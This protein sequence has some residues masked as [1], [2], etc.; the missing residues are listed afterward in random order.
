MESA[1]TFLINDACSAATVMS[2]AR[3]RNLEN[4]HQIPGYALEAEPE[5]DVYRATRD[6]TQRCQKFVSFVTQY[7]PSIPSSE[8]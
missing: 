6:H 7:L 2:I 3:Y 5:L 4:D 1:K 8:S